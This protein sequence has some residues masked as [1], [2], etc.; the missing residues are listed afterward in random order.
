ML[1]GSPGLVG[2]SG[3]QASARAAFA[4]FA[5]VCVACGGGTADTSSDDAASASASVAGSGSAG[6]VEP[7][8]VAPR[9]VK[10]TV[11]PATARLAALGS[12]VQFSAEVL[13]QNGQAMAGAA[14]VWSSDAASVAAVDG[15]GLVT[16]VGNGAAT[17][18]ASA[19]E[20][21]K[22]TTVSVDQMVSSVTVSPA[23]ETL[24]A[25]DD[26]SVS[27]E[28][29]DANGH[30]VAGA[31]FE[32]ASSDTSVVSVDGSGLVVAVAPGEVE[33]TAG[34]AGVTGRAALAVVA[35]VPTAVA[36]IPDTVALTALG[37][38]APLAADVRHQAGRVMTAADVSW[39]STDT[40]VAT[41]DSAGLV[42]AMGNGEATITATAGTV[43]E[44]AT[45]SVAQMANSVTVLPAAA[46]L[47]ALGETVQLTADA[48]DENANPVVGAEVSWESSDGAV[49]T[50]GAGGL[51]T[52]TGSGAATITAMAGA[53]SGAVT[54][55][56]AGYTLS[57]TVSDGRMEGLGVFGATLR[58]ENAAGESVTTG[59]DGQYRFSNILGQVEVT[60]T[61]VPSYFVQTVQL[62]V[63]SGDRTLDFVLEHTGVP[64]YSGTVWITPH[65]LGP[66]DPT[67]LGSVTY[68]GRGMREVY[69]WRA[70]MWITVDAYLFEV[71]FGEQ[72]VEFQVNP[73]FGSEEA[74]REQVDT[75]APA[76]GHL[77]AVLMSK[78]REVE[79]NAGEGLPRA[80]SY[81][82]LIVIHTDDEALQRA[83]RDG[84]LEEV[85]LHEAAHLTLD[86][87]YDAPGWRSAQR[88]DGA[89]ISEYARDHSDREDLAESFLSYFAVRHRPDRLTVAELRFMMMTTPN[90][91][92]YFD[93]QQFDMSPYT[94][95]QV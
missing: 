93:E 87:F 85:Y 6:I 92:A 11:T 54:V 64:P 26:L 1:A 50:V 83:L 29:V 71:Q 38:T 41:V 48:L 9:P 35:A 53:A 84:F 16:A 74:A 23:A 39:T 20:V 8:A 52:A 12:T 77:P 58:L 95:S 4:V 90:R 25:R 61:A 13:D 81:D 94:P 17:I 73:E 42:T 3:L 68:T 86:P 47:T 79:I 62:T 40:T 36:V 45:V 49:A 43:S 55:K 89:F 46:D 24:V 37:Q 31:E 22:S 65:I 56:V 80:S 27:A 10:V 57:G 82:G 70:A 14:I 28:A 21:S 7:E 59:A 2:M 32:W 60:V 30:A 76:M 19:G 78:L 15:S 18:T 67:S 5:V 51:V 33:I 91:L 88:A 69:D 72:T 66:S 75:F 44:T 34:S 63:D